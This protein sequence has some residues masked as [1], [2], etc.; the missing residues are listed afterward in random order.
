VI[1]VWCGVQHLGFPGS[2]ASLWQQ[3][4]RA[5]RRSQHSLSVYVGFDGPLDQHFMR[6]PQDL[7]ARPIECVQVSLNMLGR[8]LQ[9][10]VALYA[11]GHCPGR[12]VM[13]G[14]LDQGLMQSWTQS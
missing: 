1:I 5:G 6:Q 2:V 13:S 10:F 4:G 14:G 9:R 12:F 3:A 11:S 8:S 7:F